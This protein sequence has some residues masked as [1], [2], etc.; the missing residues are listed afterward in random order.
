MCNLQ[1]C[2]SHFFQTNFIN[3]KLCCKKLKKK[4]LKKSVASLG[5]R[6]IIAFVANFVKFVANY[7]GVDVQLAI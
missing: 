6:F 7:S 5:S 1:S 2:L 4:L 3:S